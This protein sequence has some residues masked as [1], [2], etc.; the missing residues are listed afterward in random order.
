MALLPTLTALEIVR[1][2]ARATEM[3]PFVIQP[4]LAIDPMTQDKLGAIITVM[5]LVGSFPG[6]FPKGKFDQPIAYHK[7]A[8]VAT[9]GS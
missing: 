2:S 3:I 6:D 7:L 8:Q 5:N 4:N 9:K 1:R